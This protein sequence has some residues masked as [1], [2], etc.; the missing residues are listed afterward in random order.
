MKKIAVKTLQPGLTFS[1]PVYIEGNN[2]LVPA[3]VAIRKKD[4]ERLNSWGIE[5]VETDGEA[6]AIIAEKPKK[7]PGAEA[8]KPAEADNAPAELSSAENEAEQSVPAAKPKPNLLSLTEVQENAG[9]YRSYTELIEQLDIVFTNISEGVSIEARSIDNISSRL[10]QAVRDQRDS[11]IGYILGGEVTGHEMA[12]SSVNAAILSALIAQEL[13]LPNHKIMQIITGAL[14]HDVGMLRLPKDILDKR[15]GL[16]EAELQRMQA[17]PLYTHKIVAKE[18][19]YPE[20]VG[21][22]A[23]QHHE[24][25]DGE[26]YPRRISGSAIDMGARIVSVADAFEAMVSQKSY[27]NSMVGYQAMKN[28]LSD[29]SRRFDPDVLKAFIQTM[30]I[31]PIGSI[32]LLNNG[33]LARVTE[34]HGDA[35]LRPK[36]RVLVDEFGKT[37]KQEEGDLIDLL[38]EKSLFIAKAV[39]PKEIA[40]K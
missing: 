38:T 10:L 3:G 34:V 7:V 23:I 11:F 13:K 14:L 28:L 33:A 32:I 30:G 15:G 12:K 31:Y 29:N 35:P 40:K 24:R 37:F 26:G 27:R 25:W 6:Q 36:I 20:D 18:L 16:S 4:I 39:D 21:L 19:L 1:E 2:L 8:A 22:I 9:A 17:H 5:T